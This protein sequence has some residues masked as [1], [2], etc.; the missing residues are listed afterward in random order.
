MVME[1][2]MLD[3]DNGQYNY[4]KLKALEIPER[5]RV[6]N[7]IEGLLEAIYGFKVKYH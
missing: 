6:Y 1:L 2:T 3:F 7:S 4:S 5:G